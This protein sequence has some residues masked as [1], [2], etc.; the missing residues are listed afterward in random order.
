MH[1]YLENGKDMSKLL[2]M[3]NR[4]L[5]NAYVLLIGTKIVDLK[6]L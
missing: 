2:L 3:T 1:Q 6:L 4:K 5:H